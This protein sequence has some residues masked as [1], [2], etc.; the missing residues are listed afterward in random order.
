MEFCNERLLNISTTSFL[1]ITTNHESAA[2]VQGFFA[3]VL[4]LCDAG[5][6][7]DGP[8]GQDSRL[9]EAQLPGRQSQE[10]LLPDSAGERQVRLLPHGQRIQVADH[11]FVQVGKPAGVKPAKRIDLIIHSR[12]LIPSPV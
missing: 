9:A 7:L 8:L 1:L 5:A 4:H 12:P 10:E 2:S 11:A 3:P 6:E